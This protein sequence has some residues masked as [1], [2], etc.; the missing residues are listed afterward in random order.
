MTRQGGWP[1]SG[2]GGRLRALREAA[3]LTQLQLGDRAGCHTM[4]IAK[5]EA[6]TQ[7]PA[8]PLVLQLADALGVSTEEFRSRGHEPDVAPPRRGR[9]PKQK[10]EGKPPPATPAAPPAEDLE[11]QAE[12]GPA[13]T[14]GAKPR[15]PRAQR[16]KGK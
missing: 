2:F 12:A 11:G 1:A 15:R 4:T 9:P 10:A 8:W 3:G 7:E 6:G 16:P 13:A 5:L 14:R